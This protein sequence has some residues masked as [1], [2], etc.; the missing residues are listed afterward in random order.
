MLDDFPGRRLNI[1]A[2][3]PDSRAHLTRDRVTDEELAISSR[4]N[5]ADAV[6]GERAGA[7]DRGVTDPPVVLIGQATR[8]CRCGKIAVSVQGH[9]A[10]RPGRNNGSI[11]L[12]AP[13]LG[14][15][16]RRGHKGQ[17]LLGR[18][19][20]G[21]WPRKHHV[22]AVIHDATREID[23]VRDMPQAGDGTDS[24]AVP[25]HQTGIEFCEAFMVQHRA[26]PGVQDA[27][28]LQDVYDG[29][30]RIQAATARGQYRGTG[31]QRRVHRVARLR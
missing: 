27:A 8:R 22:L 9:R 23:R 1:L 2:L 7:D 15:E 24:A 18:K 12:L 26:A 13:P 29:L 17:A 4:R 11:E 6:F 10:D 25:V 14:D 28:I 16:V 21:T 5:G 30:D 3:I 19:L 31:L 20:L